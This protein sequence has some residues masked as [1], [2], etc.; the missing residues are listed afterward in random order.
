M[1]EILF[2]LTVIIF[3]GYFF[4]DIL[5]KRKDKKDFICRFFGIENEI[6]QIKDNKTNEQLPYTRLSKIYDFAI[7]DAFETHCLS[8]KDDEKLIDFL[9]AK[10]SNICNLVITLVDF[11]NRKFSGE[12]I[13]N[14]LVVKE[15]KNVRMLINTI[16]IRELGGDLAQK[17]KISNNK[18]YDDVRI[19]VLKI[20]NDKTKND[21][22]NRIISAYEKFLSRSIRITIE[23][24]LSFYPNKGQA[25]RYD[26][27]YYI[28]KN[29]LHEAIIELSKK[30]KELEVVAHVMSNVTDFEMKRIT[31]QYSN[32]EENIERSKLVRSLIKLNKK[33]N[34]T[35]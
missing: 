18:N 21:K 15:I 14:N 10:F 19:N 32:E 9:Y 20:L 35:N 8:K 12:Y 33:I 13:S 11:Q 5:M 6:Q 27:K 4:G 28:E 24:Y 1:N 26:F 2:F 23:E 30:G 22:I 3:A 17:N 7:C 16:A 25:T 34:E 29:M 31:L